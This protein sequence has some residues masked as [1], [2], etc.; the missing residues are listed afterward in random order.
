[1]PS[2]AGNTHIGQR[3]LNEDC[4]FADVELG[5][6]VVADGMGGHKHGEVASAIVVETLRREANNGNALDAA[7]RESHLEVKRGVE[8]GRGGQGMGS[9]VV[10][11]KFDGHDYEICWIGDCRAYLW[12]GELVQVTRDHS[13]VEQLLSLGAMT[14]EEAQGSS[15]R[16]MITQAVGVSPDEEL[17][18]GIVH[19][20]L[21]AGQEL[22]LCS[23]GLNDVLTGQAIGD[24]LD[25]G[26]SLEERCGQLVE[27]VVQAGGRD[28]VTAL[29]VAPDANAGASSRPP[30]VS[31]ARRD[32]SVEYF[33]TEGISVFGA[34]EDARPANAEEADRTSVRMAPKISARPKKAAASPV[35]PAPGR[36]ARGAPGFVSSLLQGVAIGCLIVGLLA[37][38]N[39]YFG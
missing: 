39:W 34:L 37:A 26:G 32:G 36:T 24:I 16:N 7:I 1:M 15:V 17:E 20:T 27:A 28:N 2:M 33:S 22:L 14:W 3:E 23:D 11:A 38:A 5:L 29:L 9:A 12:D 8:A 31:V 10:A 13:Y 25:G 21:G 6:A 4:Y 35:R 18:V 19:G 30:A